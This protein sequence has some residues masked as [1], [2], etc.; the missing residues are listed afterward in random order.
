M[1]ASDSIGYNTNKNISYSIPKVVNNSTMGSTNMDT[2]D[3]WLNLA[4]AWIYHIE[5][6]SNL[7]IATGGEREV[8][9]S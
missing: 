5:N 4:F 3:W 1:C 7:Q 8:N 9:F 2:L 6:E